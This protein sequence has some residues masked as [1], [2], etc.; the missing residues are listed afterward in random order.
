MVGEGCRFDSF[1]HSGDRILR[2]FDDR[3]FCDMGRAALVRSGNAHRLRGCSLLGGEHI[4]ASSQFR[5]CSGVSAPAI[6]AIS[7]ASAAS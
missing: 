6:S 2:V 3:R 4:A 5:S 7:R 1:D